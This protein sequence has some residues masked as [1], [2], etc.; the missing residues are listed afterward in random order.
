MSA[1]VV[2]AGCCCNGAD[3]SFIKEKSG[4][5]EGFKIFMYLFVLKNPDLLNL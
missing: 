1:I 4:M 3:S 5:L 2:L